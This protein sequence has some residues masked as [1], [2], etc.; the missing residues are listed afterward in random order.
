MAAPTDTVDN[1]VQAM[2]REKSNRIQID[3]DV[4]QTQ[5]CLRAEAFPLSVW[6]SQYSPSLMQRIGI[7][8]ATSGEQEAF[9]VNGPPGTGKTTLLKEIEA[10]EI[11]FSQV[12][13]EYRLALIDYERLK[14]LSDAKILVDILIFL[15]E[16]CM[17]GREDLGNAKNCIRS[18][19]GTKKHCCS[20]RCLQ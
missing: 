9:S 4:E 14:N 6:P 20:C 2:I 16:G 3:T 19:R 17:R 11:A 7:N 10:K 8:L 18:K 5:H 13:K 12:C 1:Y 15:A